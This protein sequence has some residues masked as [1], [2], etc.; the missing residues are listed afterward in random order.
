[1]AVSTCVPISS[2]EVVKEAWLFK[3]VLTPS[4]S[5]PSRKVTVPVGVPALGA[6]AITVAVKL[7]GCTVNAWLGDKVSVVVVA[8]WLTVWFRA[9]EVLMP[10]FGS[11]L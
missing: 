11:P 8:A 6:V 7:L 2:P 5:V 10:K 4:T 3:R 1:M 9:A